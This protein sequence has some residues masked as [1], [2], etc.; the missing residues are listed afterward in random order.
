MWSFKLIRSW[1]PTKKCLNLDLLYLYALL[2]LAVSSS[3]IFYPY[4]STVAFYWKYWCTYASKEATC[5]VFNYMCCKN[6]Y[7]LLVSAASLWGKQKDPVA[8]DFLKSI[9]IAEERL[10]PVIECHSWARRVVQVTAFLCYSEVRLEKKKAPWQLNYITK[11][12]ELSK[13]N[14]TW[15]TLIKFRSVI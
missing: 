10:G 12:V 9:G 11:K 4:G 7:F 14:N 8:K 15:H 1:V 3:C 6:T 13:Q 5:S 2:A